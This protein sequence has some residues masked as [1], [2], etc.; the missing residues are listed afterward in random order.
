[1]N[2]AI[3]D[4]ASATFTSE[5]AGVSYT[6]SSS[7]GW[8]VEEP[9]DEI[10]DDYGHLVGN[11]LVSKAGPTIADELIFT[12][13]SSVN[14]SSLGVLY[15]SNYDSN[16]WTLTDLT[17]NSTNSPI[18]VAYDDLDGQGTGLPSNTISMNWTN[19]EKF[20]L[21]RTAGTIQ[22]EVPPTSA[23]IGIDNLKTSPASAQGYQF[24]DATIH[25]GVN[26]WVAD[27]VAAEAQYG[28]ISTWDV[29]L[30]TDMSELF[31]D[32]TSFNDDI[33]SLIHI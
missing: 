10:E 23:F 16:I 2:N 28:H 24:T 14:L 11:M 21:K 22:D 33:L 15:V 9:Y 18:E 4:T 12:F 5:I 7:N 1:M 6:I 32:K 17:L 29:S 30:V 13:N 19:V 26:D 25:G 20:S 27:P 8:Y 31:K 3:Y